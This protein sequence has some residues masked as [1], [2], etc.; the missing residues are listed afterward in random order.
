MCFSFHQ[1]INHAV[2]VRQVQHCCQSIRDVSQVRL[3]LDKLLHCTYNK[4]FFG[5]IN[6]EILLKDLFRSKLEFLYGLLIIIQR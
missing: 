4:S 3:K 1:D 6:K 5:S 2:C